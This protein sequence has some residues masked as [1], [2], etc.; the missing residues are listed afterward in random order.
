M[1]KIN[2]SQLDI[3]IQWNLLKKKEKKKDVLLNYTSTW[4]NTSM[5]NSS[6]PSIN[7]NEAQQKS[8]KVKRSPDIYT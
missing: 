7:G 8:R 5:K 6:L 4:L 3:E 2:T 1:E